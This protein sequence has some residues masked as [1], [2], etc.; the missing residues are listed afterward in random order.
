MASG[1]N[2]F[3]AVGAL[4]GA[5]TASALGQGSLIP[6][7]FY[8]VQGAPFTA[9]IES[10]WDGTLSSGPG[11]S[12][13]RV[14]RDS[15][16]RQ[17]FETPAADGSPLPQV[18][19]YDPAGE[20]VI[21]LDA[22]RRTAIVTAMARVG[23]TISIDPAAPR[24]GPCKAEGDGDS[25][26]SRQIA[27]L[28]A[29]GHHLVQT[30]RKPA[31]DVTLTRDL[32]LS[33][34][35]SMPLAAVTDDARLGRLT[36]TVTA[37]DAGEPDAV[38]FVIPAGYEVAHWSPAAPA[39]GATPGISRIGSGVSA[40]VVLSAPKPQFSEEAR[41]DEVSGTVLVYLQV[42]ENGLPSHV[43]VLRGIGHGLDEKAVEAVKQYKFQP[44]MR[45]GQPVI[46]EMNVQVDFR[47]YTK[48]P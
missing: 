3:L 18:I 15:A 28:E 25:L 8:A 41:R 33:T 38:L 5:A 35:Y 26:G 17:R 45:D 22:A 42:D 29:C 11:R 47:I 21:K 40:P 48:Q 37:L 9:T 27:G 24:S 1:W 19:I 36:Q 6:P 32:W 12:V 43:R 2:R 7:A 44:A 39:A 23:R 46:V 4:F 16:G 13:S 30:I 14:V 34:S 20:K 10:V 31:G